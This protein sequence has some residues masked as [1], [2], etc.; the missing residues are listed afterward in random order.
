VTYVLAVIPVEVTVAL[1]G[2]TVSVIVFALTALVANV[3]DR[4]SR[5]R[6]TYARAFQVI[7]AY[8]ELPYVVRRR[9][10]GDVSAAADERA[11]ISEDLRKV[12]VD[13]SYFS[14]WMV[15]S[16]LA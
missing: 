8:K 3:K 10:A 2:G 4:D 16:P 5:R 13:L 14:A 15:L 7:A 12:Q 11:R 1:I 9:R 6:D